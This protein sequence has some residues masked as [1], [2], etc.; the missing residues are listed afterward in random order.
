M[1]KLESS[2]AREKALTAVNLDQGSINV[3]T[4]DIDFAGKKIEIEIAAD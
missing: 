3:E 4:E 1:L 2:L